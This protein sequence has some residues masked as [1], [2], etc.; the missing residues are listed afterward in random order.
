VYTIIFRMDLTNGSSILIHFPLTLQVSLNASKS[1]PTMSLPYTQTFVQTSNFPK[2]FYLTLS[3]HSSFIMHLS[4]LYFPCDFYLL[5]SLSFYI[6]DFTLNFTSTYMLHIV[7]Y[8]TIYIS[9]KTHSTIYDK[10]V[11]SLI[12]S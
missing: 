7:N 10:H 4:L 11:S 3:A 8:K 9:L 12:Y 2:L 6:D 1:H 5:Y